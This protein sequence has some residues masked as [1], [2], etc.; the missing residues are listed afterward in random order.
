MYDLFGV[1]AGFTCLQLASNSASLEM[2]QYLA[3]VGGKELLLMVAQIE[4][5]VTI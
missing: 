4:V 3:E 5:R 2:V 1:K